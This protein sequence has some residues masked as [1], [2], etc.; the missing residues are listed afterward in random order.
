[1]AES[2]R[3]TRRPTTKANRD[4]RLLLLD[5][6]DSFTYNLLQYFGELGAQVDVVRNDVE[7]VKQLLSRKPDGFVISPGPGEPRHAGVSVPAV[8]AFAGAGIPV[9]GVCLG[10]QSI[11]EAYG[12]RIIRAP[13]IMHGKTSQI[14]HE[15]VGVFEGLPNPFE[16]TRY[17]S[18]IIDPETFPAVLEITAR[19]RE[20]EIMGVRHREF[21]VEGVQFHPE[22]IMTT[23]GKM[24]LDRFL[25]ICEERR[26][27]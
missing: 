5:N 3:N 4:V 23:E 11:G 7:T 14:L 19:T 9:F 20:G 22:S 15:N 26:K 16:A 12:G 21:P 8:L 27:R 1:M 10:H 24:L 13:R 25:D 17:H 18:L 2:I 6:Y